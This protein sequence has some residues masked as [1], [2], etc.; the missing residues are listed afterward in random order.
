MFVS[1]ELVG[2]LYVFILHLGGSIYKETEIW[3]LCSLFAR[4][5]DCYPDP[6]GISPLLYAAYLYC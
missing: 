4:S 6:G 2:C 1:V 3:I 5:T